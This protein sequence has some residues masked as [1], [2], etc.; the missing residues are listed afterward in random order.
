MQI[1]I[2]GVSSD[3]QLSPMVQD[4]E[5]EDEIEEVVCE[6]EVYTEPVVKEEIVEIDDEQPE[7]DIL[8][9]DSVDV[10]QEDDQPVVTLS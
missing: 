10:K 6:E 3:Q 5:D 2:T 8:Q 7:M 4:V 1:A 9:M